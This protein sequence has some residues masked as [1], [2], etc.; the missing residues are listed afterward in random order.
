MKKRD[1]I[2]TIRALGQTDYLDLWIIT[3]NARRLLGDE[4]DEVIR[5]VVLD[6]LEELLTNGELVAGELFPP[7]EFDPWPVDPSEAVARIRSGWDGL[8]RPIQVG[9]VA[10]FRVIR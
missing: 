1:L 9:D 2:E 4:D 5:R 8:E 6:V 10:W 3:R 7:G